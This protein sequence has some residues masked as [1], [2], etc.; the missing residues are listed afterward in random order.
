MGV[1]KNNGTPKSSILI[2]FSII[3]HQFWGTII[4][5]NTHIFCRFTTSQLQHDGKFWRF[6]LP[7]LSQWIWMGDRHDPQPAKQLRQRRCSLSCIAS[8]MW[9]KWFWGHFFWMTWCSTCMLEV[10]IPGKWILYGTKTRRI[11]SAFFSPRLWLCWMSR[12][13][14]QNMILFTCPSTLKIPAASATLSS[15][16]FARALSWIFR[17]PSNKLS[18]SAQKPTRHAYNH[19]RIHRISTRFIVQIIFFHWGNGPIPHSKYSRIVIVE[20]VT[21]WLCYGTL[22]SSWLALAPTIN[23]SRKPRPWW[24]FGTQ[25]EARRLQGLESNQPKGRVNV[26]KC[27]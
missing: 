11:C 17:V 1:S 4:F 10:Q 24:C 8:E 16:W 12:V 6:F 21:L 25:G 26:G 7:W 5:G 27:I 15:T 18:V 19:P 22:I 14:P 2:G 9:R 3:N 23:L 20:S 13:S